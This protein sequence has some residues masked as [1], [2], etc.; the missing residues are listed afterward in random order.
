MST[1]AL[2][3]RAMDAMLACLTENVA[4]IDDIIIATKTR[5][6]LLNHLCAVFERIQQY[7]FHGQTENVSFSEC[8]SCNWVLYLIKF[9]TN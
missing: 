9:K 6:E 1:P 2:F 7:G 8:R 3:H 5:D 4:F